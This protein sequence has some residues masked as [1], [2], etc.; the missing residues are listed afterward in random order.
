V[1]PSAPLILLLL[2]L[3]SP[4]A[5][6]LVQALF[7]RLFRL[8]GL[9]VA[10]QILVLGI[11]AIGN[12][13]ILWL[14]WKW[15]FAALTGDW[16]SIACGLILVLSTYQAL[17]FCY[18]NLL[19]LSETSL[20]IHILMDLLVSGPVPAAELEARYGVKE[21][22]QTRVER[23]IKLGQLRRS[24]GDRFVANNRTL[25]LIGRLIHL[26]RR[27]LKLPLSPD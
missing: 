25:L 27:V 26:W 17:S 15:V 2:L 21:M 22:M 1:R 13:A 7:S 12:V 9:R 16:L 4:L 20:H 5:I 8:L 19:N 6:C 14:A 18:F 3:A 11:V 10:P 24:Q 23:M